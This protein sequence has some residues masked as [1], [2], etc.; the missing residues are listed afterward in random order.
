MSS[1]L[2][3]LKDM[4]IS[5][6]SL[7]LPIQQQQKIQHKWIISD[8][9][10]WKWHGRN[11]WSHC[12][13]YYTFSGHSCILQI[14]G[15]MP[16][17]LLKRL[18]VIS[19]HPWCFANWGPWF[20][21]LEMSCHLWQQLTHPGLDSSVPTNYCWIHTNC[22]SWRCNWVSAY[23]P[24]EIT[25]TITINFILKWKQLQHLALFTWDLE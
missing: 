5:I 10:F 19:F 4:G 25:F 3:L 7:C 2:I 18:I 1:P 20:S 15:H 14:P 22:G 17:I 9:P 23:R 13:V 8:F 21:V 24:D 11:N 16:S 6:L 12:L